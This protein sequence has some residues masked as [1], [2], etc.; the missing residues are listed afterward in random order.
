MATR[1]VS[2]T[3]LARFSARSG[4]LG[5][6][7]FSLLRGSE[8]I[9][10]HQRIQK[11]RG[12]TYQAEVSVRHT[13]S[14][15]EEA[16]EVFGRIDGLESMP[17]GPRIEEIKTFRTSEDAVP[18]DHAVHVMQGKLYAWMWWENFGVCPEL[19]IR[20]VH[21]DEAMP[22]HR[23]EVPLVP[24]EL[25]EE[26]DRAFRKYLGYCQERDAW[27]ESRNRTLLNLEFPFAEMRPGQMELMQEVDL[28]LEQGGRLYAQAPTGIGKTLAVLLP[29]LRKM[30]EGCFDT[31]VIATCRN[32][33]KNVFSEA[34]QILAGQG[35]LV[36]ALPMAS[37]DRVCDQVGK[38]CDCSRCPGAIGFYD[39]L[40]EAMNELR[41]YTLWERGVWQGVAK[42]HNLCPYAFL[43]VAA[44]EADVVIG[45]INYALSPSSR[46][47]FLFADAPEKV[48]LI[49]DEAHH[50]PDRTR[51]MLSATLDAPF[52]RK[53]LQTL[54]A[55][56]LGVVAPGVRG[57]LR[58]IRTYEVEN[59]DAE[60]LPKAGA[61]APVSLVM[62]CF[63]LAEEVEA[64][65]AALP[66]QEGDVRLELMR[67]VRD[68]ALSVERRLDSHVCYG[69]DRKLHHFCR[70]SAEWLS[71]ELRL[72]HATVLFSAALRPLDAYRQQTGS[73]PGDRQ[74]E[75]RS[76]FDPARFRV[77]IETSIPLVWKARTA[78]MYDRLSSRLMEFI[79]SVSGRTLVYFPSY[80]VLDEV[81]K[82]VPQDDLWLGPI[83]VQPRGLQE[84]DAE[85]FLAPFRAASGPVTG[86][87]VLGGALNEGIDL[88]GNA[89][90][91]VAVVSIGLPAVCKENELLSQWHQQQGR[92][93]FLYAYTLPG[94][95]RVQQA[96][97]RVIRGP[98]DEGQALLIDPRF[99]HPFYR[100]LLG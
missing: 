66:A 1:R 17:S 88:P 83:Y 74:I 42:R 56:C 55:E 94:L 9:R 58:K 60:G 10:V 4:D 73:E 67:Q 84:A 47:E 20:Y 8:G 71:G 98:E 43:M 37:R 40:E 25:D 99:D 92:E 95:I 61:E 59:L 34:L 69:E 15:G 14:R 45:D 87:A 96:I 35:M 50:L 5:S 12:P 28:T 41:T 27:R 90:N 86:F 51:S 29:A 3:E 85:T 32:S 6:R 33:G 78:S 80:A 72:L 76:P 18:L 36:H 7:H 24:E 57:L 21:P 26:V 91:A 2:V 77:E 68:F 44:R 48:C 38:P 23:V 79:T 30:G 46:L 63:Q 75:L 81:A 62:P 13:W 97:G 31:L 93:G 89:L 19:V 64:S 82:R 39:R 11:D 54:P 16:V 53:S 100:E 49:L 65:L 52:I 70:D 22:E